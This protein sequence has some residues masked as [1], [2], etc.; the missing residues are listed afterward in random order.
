MG[1]E[2]SRLGGNARLGNGARLHFFA[3]YADAYLTLTTPSTSSPLS[4]G[5][6]GGRVRRKGVFRFLSDRISQVVTD[7]AVV[8]S[9]RML[10]EPPS[11]AHQC[12]QPLGGRTMK[13]YALAVLAVCSAI[14]VSAG[15]THAASGT[16]PPGADPETYHMLEVFGDVLTYA[17]KSHAT[18]VDN[19]RAL[20]AAISGLL[21]SL[22][23]HSDYVTPEVY[24]EMSNSSTSGASVGL[25]ITSENGIIR[26]VGVL[27]NSPAAKAGIKIDDRIAAI[28]G[29][30]LPTL[31][32][33]DVTNHLRGPVGEPISLTIFRAGD[34]PFTVTMARARVSQP[35]AKLSEVG[36]YEV[37]QI[38][39]FY[40]ALSADL[41]RKLPPIIAA[42]PSPR[43]LVL[44]LRDCKGGLLAE[45]VGVTGLF[46]SRG[47]VV[48]LT[49][50]DPQNPKN[51]QHYMSRDTDLVV[52]TLP[53]VVLVNEATGSGCEI[54][55]AALQD[56]GRAKVVGMPTFGDGTIQTLIPLNQGRDG[57][58]KL[59]TAFILRPS[60]KPIQKLGV[61]PDV[62]VAKSKE[63]AERFAAHMIFSE[64]TT[65]NAPEPTSTLDPPAL[66]DAPVDV[67]PASFN[68]DYQLDRAL[69]LLPQ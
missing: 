62:R 13:Q 7:D 29:Q 43:G 67:P 28:N 19:K 66:H 15:Q 63:D 40:G 38:K 34:A 10:V 20:Q 24:A 59:T 27:D 41:K 58:L 3:H 49:G 6:R 17:D 47:M 60:G 68:G 56:N 65:F 14:C 9:R 39:E 52:G 50:R 5:G 64:R 30:T 18:P 11:I 42:K 45:A 22:D 2:V 69:A 23:S 44:D 51:I 16:P 37:L 61:N 4:T 21:R 31:S 25:E 48:T 33:A 57:A 12:G 35:E 32:L 46:Q 8:G 1:G 55:A 36:P 53:I 26:V 54:I